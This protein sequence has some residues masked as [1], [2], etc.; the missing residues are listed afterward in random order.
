[1]LD[2]TPPLSPPLL[3]FRLR[4]M[5]SVGAILTTQGTGRSRL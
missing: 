5:W 1:L 3:P 2:A 4:C